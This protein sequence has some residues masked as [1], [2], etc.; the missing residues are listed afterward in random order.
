M[1]KTIIAAA[2]LLSCTA[3][4]C[5]KNNSLLPEQQAAATV[6]GGYNSCQGKRILG[7]YCLDVYKPVCGCDGIT[8]SNGCYAYVA[9]IKSY[10]QGA[11]DG[12]GGEVRTK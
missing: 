6:E 8:Y 3:I 10:T 11:C 12:S 2:V 4:S 7:V 9:G 5:K 1:K